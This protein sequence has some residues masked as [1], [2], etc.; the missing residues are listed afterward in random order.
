M[1]GSPTACRKPEA[2]PTTETP[3]R[4]MAGARRRA[5]ASWAPPRAG[6][7]SRAARRIDADVVVGCDGFHGPSRASVPGPQVWERAYPFAW[8]GV[9]ADVA[10]STD[11]LIYAWHPDGFAM[12]SMRSPRVSRFYLQGAPDEEIAV[13]GDVAAHGALR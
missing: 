9:L 6:G 5:L 11:E 4:P 12:H 3:A 2:S 7:R 1:G 8:L 13:V 10:P